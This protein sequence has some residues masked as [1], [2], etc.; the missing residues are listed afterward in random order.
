M[1]FSNLK[2][3]II[4]ERVPEDQTVHPKYYFEVLNKLTE[5]EKGGFVENDAW[6]LHHDNEPAII[7]LWNNFQWTSP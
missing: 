4:I 7:W 5:K 1:F 6:I 3:V 2:D